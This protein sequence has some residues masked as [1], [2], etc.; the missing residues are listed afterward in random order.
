MVNLE[1]L[2]KAE[3]KLGFAEYLTRPAH[4][5]SYNSAALKHVTNASVLAV[6]ALTD[7]AVDSTRAM[8]LALLKFEEPEA[9]R[10]AKSLMTMC[11]KEGGADRRTIKLAMQDIREFIAWMK[12]LQ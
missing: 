12:R 4:T 2:K 6:Q 3:E 5:D 8:Q 9:K 1:K 11:R 10:F 7:S